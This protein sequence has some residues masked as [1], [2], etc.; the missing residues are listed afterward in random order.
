MIFILPNWLPVNKKSIHM[1]PTQMSS[2]HSTVTVILL[3]TQQNSLL[4]ITEGDLNW[5]I[6][7]TGLL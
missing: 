3:P 6:V 7:K 4:I 1:C 2:C 5:L